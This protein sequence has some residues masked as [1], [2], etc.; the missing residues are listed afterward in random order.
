MF[1]TEGVGVDWVGLQPLE[2][3]WVVC[4]SYYVLDHS[5]GIDSAWSPCVYCGGG[6]KM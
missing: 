1:L 6:Y 4:S 2:G 5:A 3:V